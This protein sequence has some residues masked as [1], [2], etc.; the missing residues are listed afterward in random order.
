MEKEERA[1]IAS[2]A[3]KLLFSVKEYW[4]EPAKGNYIPNKE[5]A[6]LS[7]AGFGV[8][9]TTLLASAIGLDASNFLV[10]ASIG[11][12]P[13]DLS[14]MLVVAN[15]VGIP[16]GIF[17]SWYYDNHKLNGGKF[18]PF[19]KKTGLP[20]VLITTAFVWLPYENMQYLTKAIV[21]WFMYML[22]NIFLCFYNESYTYFQQIITPNAQERANVMS[23]SQV[24]YSLAPTI[25]GFAIPT[26]AGLTWGLN[27]IWTY[28]VIYP[29]FTV[30]GLIIGTIFFRKVKERL[31]LP[32]KQPEPVRMRSERLLKISIIG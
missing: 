30:T 3:K 31:I 25:T 8:H 4:H 6:S 13:M 27:N 1:G 18:L 16:I 20:I 10:G 24:I 32:K 22:L 12:K 28:R 26:I 23:I 9:W 17:R 19:I 11:L 29:F 14:V 7:G 15:L 21:V 5:I 2:K